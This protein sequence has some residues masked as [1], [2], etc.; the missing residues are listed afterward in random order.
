MME[1]MVPTEPLSVETI[2][3]IQR[4]SEIYP[5]IPL[6]EDAR[7]L[8]LM[9]VEALPGGDIEQTILTPPPAP[10][11]SGTN[12][13]TCRVKLPR[14]GY[15]VVAKF[16]DS[17]CAA[18]GGLCQTII[19]TAGSDSCAYVPLVY[20]G[21]FTYYYWDKVR[22][23]FPCIT[24]YGWFD[25]SIDYPIEL[26]PS[27]QPEDRLTNLTV[28]YPA[29]EILVLDQMKL[30]VTKSQAH[31]GW[32]RG[33]EIRWAGAAS[34]NSQDYMSLPDLAEYFQYGPAA[35]FYNLRW[36]MSHEIYHGLE[37]Q[38]FIRGLRCTQEPN[39]IWDLVVPDCAPHN[40]CTTGQSYQGSWSEGKADAY[41]SVMMDLFSNRAPGTVW[42]STCWMPNPDDPD[43]RTG[44]REKNI[45]AYY[46]GLLVWNPVHTMN[47]MRYGR[48]TEVGGQTHPAT[49]LW[50]Y[51]SV[52]NDVDYEVNRW[53]SVH[54][55]GNYSGEDKLYRYNI[56][57]EDTTTVIPIVTG[58]TT[59]PYPGTGEYEQVRWIRSIGPN[60]ISNGGSVQVRVLTPSSGDVR[61]SIY[62]VLGRWVATQRFPN[63]P[64]GEVNL[65]LRIP[66]LPTGVY[67]VDFQDDGNH[68][69]EDSA[70]LVVIR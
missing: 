56:L 70:K 21:P 14:P 20:G 26:Y 10:G 24:P 30:I 62:T 51:R 5:P 4:T 48:L 63:L 23:E 42:P 3:L 18:T 50:Q 45:W 22:M 66:K 29:D 37:H 12:S 43:M 34:F 36:V 25:R 65:P 60:P 7:D 57:G 9:S 68:R 13:L 35:G 15:R 19:Y 46:Y 49:T 58:V 28:A 32:S 31:F 27:S 8:A 47:V 11:G 53:V 64:S 6:S 61:L 40:G 38:I 17:G 55:P 69:A 2:D 52:F 1:Q 59:P 67:I 41:A 54:Y 16:Y 39:E 33:C 44:M